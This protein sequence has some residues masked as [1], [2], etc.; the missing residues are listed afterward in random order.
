M[1]LT[2]DQVVDA[3]LRRLVRR[4]ADTDLVADIIAE[5]NLA[6]QTVCERGLVKPWFLIQIATLT[7]DGTGWKAPL[8]A[9]F[10]DLFEEE[11]SVLAVSASTT[12][13]LTPLER[14]GRADL[15]W[16]Q[17]PVN[18]TNL[19]DIMEGY[20]LLAKQA[21][22]ASTLRMLYYKSEPLNE[23]AYGSGG[24]PAANR[25]IQFAADVLIGEVAVILGGTKLKFDAVAMTRLEALQAKAWNRLNTE[26]ISRAEM[27]KG[28]FLSGG[29]FPVTGPTRTMT[30]LS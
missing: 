27:A 6:Q 16:S 14:V 24:Q 4:S 28:R 10:I 19:F 17:T 7:V 29:L 2:R 3:I 23:T 9:D 30:A 25:W 5:L 26:T 21:T 1:A 20:L 12:P 18:T 15:E 8:P 13:G 22:A 11:P